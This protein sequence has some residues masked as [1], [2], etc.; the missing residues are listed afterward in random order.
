[1]LCE[2]VKLVL[3]GIDENFGVRE[4]VDV[5]SDC[6]G[7]SACV[8]QDG[9]RDRHVPGHRREGD[10]LTDGR[11]KEGNGRAG[12]AKIGDKGGDQVRAQAVALRAWQAARA[13]F[14][15]SRAAF[16]EARL[17][18][19]SRICWRRKARSLWGA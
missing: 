17:C 14:A 16:A 11:A 5:S 10:H 1:M 3:K 18:S 7:E 9:E 15:A 19:I 13:C 4:G 6:D 8:G 12:A 2:R